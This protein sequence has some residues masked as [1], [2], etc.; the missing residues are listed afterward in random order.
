[1]TVWIISHKFHRDFL[2][3]AYVLDQSYTS[4]NL[5]TQVLLRSNA[6][7]GVG[8]PVYTKLA[9]SFIPSATHN[10]NR[11]DLRLIRLNGTP[12]GNIWI[13]IQANDAGVPSGIPLAIS[14]LKACS[15]LDNGDD[16]YGFDIFIPPET[17]IGQ[18]YWTVLEGDYP[19]GSVCVWWKTDGQG[20]YANNELLAYSTSW[21]S[22]VGGSITAPDALFKEYYGANQRL[23]LQ[24]L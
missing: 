4:L 18:K 19:I 9:Q 10:T 5:N 20:T 3:M 14:Q 7:I 15:L 2:N 12:D 1:M 17:V 11:I 13:S 8:I 16:Y 24:D 21:Q 22:L 6:D 23:F